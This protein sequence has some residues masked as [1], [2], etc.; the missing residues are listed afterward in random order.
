MHRETLGDFEKGI[1]VFIVGMNALGL[2]MIVNGW[3]FPDNPAWILLRTF[4]YIEGIAL[5][6]I[7][8]GVLMYGLCTSSGA[9][10]SESL[11]QTTSNETDTVRNAHLC[12]S[13]RDAE[14]VSD[15]HQPEAQAAPVSP[16]VVLQTKEP[17]PPPPEPT[18][19]ELQEEAIEQI[20]GGW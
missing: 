6:L 11:I 4:F 12:D 7:F 10:K 5:I 19:E 13:S 14:D 18:A 20:I 2:G 3:D 16:A 15:L 9:A 17:E 1:L 8:G